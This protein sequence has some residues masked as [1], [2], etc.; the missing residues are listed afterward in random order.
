MTQPIP[1][2]ARRWLDIAARAALRGSGRVEPNPMVGCVII[3][4]DGA[5]AGIGHHRVFG[6]PHAEV[7]ALAACQA[8]CAQCTTKWGEMYR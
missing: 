7:E 6:G 3:G 5:L 8:R 4:A 2:H 1:K